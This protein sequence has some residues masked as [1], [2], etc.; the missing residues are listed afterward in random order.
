MQSTVGLLLCMTCIFWLTLGSDPASSVTYKPIS[1]SSFSNRQLVEVRWS[2]TQDPIIAIA[3][4]KL[5]CE[6]DPRSAR[7]EM[8][9]ISCPTE[10][11]SE[12]YLS[13]VAL[14]LIFA[15]SPKEEKA[16]LRL[17]STWRDVWKELS[18]SKKEHDEATDR[19]V[20]RGLRDIIGTSDQTHEG[21]VEQSNDVTTKALSKEPVSTISSQWHGN[22]SLS[23]SDDV[24][25][26]WASK[27]SASSY[28]HML[29]SRM[30]LPI[31]NFKNQLLDAIMNN[32]VV[33]ICGET[34][35]G[36]STQVPAF[37]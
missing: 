2:R 35:C 21:L 3:I 9:T 16:Y 32:S 36:K 6:S 31:W 23:S 14:F 19:Q 29:S 18:Q 10:A 4:D 33:I 5:I 17:P 22:S 7:I 28:Q 25:A 26:L 8:A 34:G 15:S 12:A 30:S 1:A 20:L 27:L 37:M 24:K 13:T 11:Q